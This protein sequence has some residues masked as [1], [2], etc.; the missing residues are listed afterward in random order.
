MKIHDYLKALSDRPFLESIPPMDSFY[1]Y[2]Y[3]LP[4][5]QE[6]IMALLAIAVGRITASSVCVAQEVETALDLVE[7]LAG[8][9]L[10]FLEY[11]KQRKGKDADILKT[12]KDSLSTKTIFPSMNCE[13]DKHILE[14]NGK[15]Y[16]FTG[17][18][19]IVTDE[20]G[21]VRVTTLEGNK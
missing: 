10:K 20:H 21:Q 17:C 15:P 3:H 19:A 2:T 16:E 1:T 14:V 11:E 8:N 6:I 13:Q 7:E 9:G 12:S 4:K 5:H 18:P